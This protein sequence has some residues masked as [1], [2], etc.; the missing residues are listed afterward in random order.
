MVPLALWGSKVPDIERRALADRILAVKPDTEVLKPQTRF[1]M[2]FGKPKFPKT[3]TLTS[4]LADFAGIDSWYTFHL[5]Q[6][7]QHVFLL[8]QVV[9]LHEFLRLLP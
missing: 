1:G 7:N 9:L 4:T 8:L 6:L 2:G 3:I 5:L